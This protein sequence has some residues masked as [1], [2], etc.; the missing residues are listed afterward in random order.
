MGGGNS[1]LCR[2]SMLCLPTSQQ[3]EPRQAR[4][5][6]TRIA[7]KMEN[8]CRHGEADANFLWSPMA[9]QRRYF[10]GLMESRCRSAARAV[11]TSFSKGSRIPPRRFLQVSGH[12][13]KT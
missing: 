9:F 8:S 2:L 4:R 11:F 1:A 10:D 3:V 6:D 5:G 7:V 12:I 13:L